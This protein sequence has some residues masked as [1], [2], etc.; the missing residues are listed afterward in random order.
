MLNISKPESSPINKG[1]PIYNIAVE[2][3][4]KVIKNEDKKELKEDM[5]NLLEARYN[6]GLSKYK[7]PLM[8]ED[9]RDDIE[10]CLQ[11]IGD[12]IQYLSKAIYNKKDITKLRDGIEV[13]YRISQGVNEEIKNP[14]SNTKFSR[15]WFPKIEQTEKYNPLL[16]SSGI[17]ECSG[18]LEDMDENDFESIKFFINEI[19]DYHNLNND[20]IK[21]IKNGIGNVSDLKQFMIYSDDESSFIYWLINIKNNNVIC[22]SHQHDLM[23]I[24]SLKNFNEMNTYSFF[25]IN[26]KSKYIYLSKYFN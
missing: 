2:N 23:Y 8:S 12:A 13:L 10:D 19:E 22:W 17:L 9:G 21:C 3:V 20:E 14:L 11:E 16:E 6:F 25:E 26:D 4:I 7:Q 24:I 15:N 1:I 5:L 18:K